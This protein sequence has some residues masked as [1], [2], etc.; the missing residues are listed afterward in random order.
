MMKVAWILAVIFFLNSGFCL[1]AA[2]EGEESHPID[3]AMGKAMEA[4]PSTAG[5]IEAITK[6]D[7]KWDAL[8]NKNYKELMAALDPKGQAALKNAQRAWLVYRDAEFAANDAIFGKMEGTMYIPMLAS[9]KMEVVK[10][11]ALD[12][13]RRLDMLRER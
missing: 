2:Q 9:A 4:D 5:M 1:Q 13:G 10:H 7:E 12:L 8:L 11:R 6:A 3:V